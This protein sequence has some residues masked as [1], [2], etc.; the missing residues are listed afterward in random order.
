MIKLYSTWLVLIRNHLGLTESRKKNAYIYLPIIKSIKFLAILCS[1]QGP[2]PLSVVTQLPTEPP[3]EPSHVAPLTRVEA[4]LQDTKDVR[5]LQHSCNILNKLV[6]F[7][8]HFIMIMMIVS[9]CNVLLNPLDPTCFKVEQHLIETSTNGSW[10]FGTGSWD[11]QEL[12]R[13]IN[14]SKHQ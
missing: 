8:F 13:V 12:L 7:C 5:Y 3:P 10:F 2:V 9:D 1:A 4:Q 14:Y 6:S 11:S